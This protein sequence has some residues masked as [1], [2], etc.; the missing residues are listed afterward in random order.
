MKFIITEGNL[1]G[2]IKKKLGVDLTGKIKLITSVY[3]IPIKFRNTIDVS[4]WKRLMNRYGPLYHIDAGHER[5]FLI[6]ERGNDE[7]VGVDIHEQ[8]VT[9][10]EVLEYLRLDMLGLGL[11]KII[12]M[13]FDESEDLNESVNDVKRRLRYLDD[14]FTFATNVI[15]KGKKIC[16][17]YS[18]SYMLLEAISEYMVREMYFEHFSDI[19]IASM[20]WQEMEIFIEKYVEYKFSDSVKEHWE[21]NCGNL[22]EGEITEKCWKGYT[23]KGM[24]TI[25]GKRYPNCV[26]IKK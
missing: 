23:Q 4:D 10:Q 12:D 25:F 13:Y 26:K 5:E 24:K 11:N 1:K 9:G 2:F 15:Y 19:N 22:N 3:D 14:L 20:E 21:R 16:D 18:E 7:F 8:Y 6:Q 17:L